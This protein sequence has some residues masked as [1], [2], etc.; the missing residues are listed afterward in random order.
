[1]K[2]R[3]NTYE[4][5]L[6]KNMNF[7]EVCLVGL[8]S[9]SLES[10]LGEKENGLVRKKRELEKRERVLRVLPYRNRNKNKN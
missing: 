3:S 1:M 2:N 7:R 10:R 5:V 9:S 8:G 6:D 4:D